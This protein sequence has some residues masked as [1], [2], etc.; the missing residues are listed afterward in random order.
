VVSRDPAAGLLAGVV[1]LLPP[2]RDEWG[3]A[4]RAELAGVNGTRARWGFVLGCLRVVAMQRMTARSAGYLV[5]VVGALAGV[6]AL[7]RDV[8]YVPLRIG[9]VVLVAVLV[10]ES[11][12]GRR[13]WL[14]GPARGGWVAGLVGAGGYLLVGAMAFDA[15]LD[16]RS[17][18]ENPDE[19]VHVGVPVYTALLTG[20]LVGFL[21]LTAHRSAAGARTL[22]TGAASGLG[23]AVFWL[24]VVLALPPV[25]ADILLAVVLIAV[26]MAVAGLIARDPASALCAGTVGALLIV[27]LVGVLSHVGPASLIPDL[28]RAA[29]TPAD[30]LAQSRIEV[31]DPYVG[32]L[33]LGAL[34][35]VVLMLVSVTTRRPVPAR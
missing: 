25:P 16:M 17:H 23:A 31:N 28:A 35:G 9:L 2:G 34:A 1:R 20:Y 7:A 18:T 24:V 14:F 26:A 13:R 27:L 11:W 4:M 19:M 6:V 10:A 29:L 8:A 32:L 22:A 30:D 21:A 3:R 5:L 12:L 15:V 33:F